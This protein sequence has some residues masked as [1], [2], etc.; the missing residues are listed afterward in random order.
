MNLTASLFFQK[1]KN[2]I[3]VLHP[4]FEK[5]ESN[6]YYPCYV[7]ENRSFDK[8]TSFIKIEK[9]RQLKRIKVISCIKSESS[10]SLM[11]FEYSRMR[12][13]VLKTGKKSGIILKK[14]SFVNH[15]VAHF[16]DDWIFDKFV[17]VD[18]VDL[19]N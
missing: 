5:E 3:I 14:N 4:H 13:Y 7:I 16:R 2:R 17:S 9:I 15:D 11:L 8:Q 18:R 6:T 12:L 1:E 10:L 19:S